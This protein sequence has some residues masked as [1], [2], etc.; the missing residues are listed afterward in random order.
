MRLLITILIL[1]SCNKQKQ[2]DNPKPVNEMDMVCEMVGH[3]Y[4]CENVEVIC[5]ESKGISCHFKEVQI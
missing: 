2:Y 4:R 1:A 3:L 5:Y